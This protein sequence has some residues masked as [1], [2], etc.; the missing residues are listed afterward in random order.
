MRR[1]SMCRRRPVGQRQRAGSR[2]Q[3]DRAMKR[4]KG[5][6]FGR[7]VPIGRLTR[8]RISDRDAP[9]ALG[10]TNLEYRSVDGGN[11]QR[12]D[13]DSGISNQRPEDTKARYRV[14]TDSTKEGGPDH[15]AKQPL[16]DFRLP[17]EPLRRRKAW[18][19]QDGESRCRG[20]TSMPICP[21]N[22][23]HSITAPSF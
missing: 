3:R 22:R 18:P 17:D 13:I 11:R 5:A 10:G 14:L 4:A 15:C 1:D 19:S 23:R 2:R 6:V 21:A 9:E 16:K 7:L 12:C 20:T 8:R